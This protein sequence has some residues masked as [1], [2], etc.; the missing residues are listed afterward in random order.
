MNW[1]AIGSIAEAAGAIGVIA[2]LAYLAVQVRENSSWMQRQ[3]LDSVVDRFTTWGARVRDNPEI[4]DIYLRGAES[5]EG[6]S[7][8][9]QHRFHL[10]KL[11][12]VGAI[13]T[14]FEYGNNGM[15]KAE[16]PNAARR[17]LA[18]ELASPGSKEWWE[19]FGRDSMS[20]DLGVM[21]DEM[22]RN[23]EI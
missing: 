10:T 2:T 9:D 6:L 22:T 14:V 4:V 19:R 1:D 7:D 5:F 17:W 11:E 15:I 21:V 8:V 13:E 20:D 12:I 18:R 3:A 23:G 16:T